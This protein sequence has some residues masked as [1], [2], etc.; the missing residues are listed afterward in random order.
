MKTVKEEVSHAFDLTNGQLPLYTKSSSTDRGFSH[1]HTQGQDEHAR[2]V[3]G[4]GV[5]VS[6]LTSL[7]TKRNLSST[8]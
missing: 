6:L 7:L 3:W 5:Y 1:T 4:E 8:W 2:K